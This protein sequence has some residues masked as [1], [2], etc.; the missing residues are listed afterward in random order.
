MINQEYH[1]DITR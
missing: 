1:K